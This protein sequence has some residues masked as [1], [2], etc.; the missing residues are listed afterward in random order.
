MSRHYYILAALLLLIFACSKDK[1]Y[2]AS[3]LDNELENVIN[4]Y[5]GTDEFILPESDDYQ[6]IPQDP[7]NP[8]SQGKIELGKM[9]FYETGLALAPIHDVAEGTYS[10]ATCHIPSAGFRPG[11]P[12]GIADG[13]A[14]FGDNGEGRFMGGLYDETELDVQGAR[15]LSVLNVAFVENTSWNG[16]FGGGGVNVG[17]EA[18]WSQDTTTEINHLGYA[19]LESQNIEGLKIHRMVVNKEIAD[20][21]GYTSYFDACFPEYPEEERY[22]L[23]TASFAISAYLRSLLTTE[24]PFQL[25]LKGD[26]T[27]LTDSEKRGGILFFD[28]ANCASCHREANLGSNTFYALGVN[29]LFQNAASFNTDENDPRNFGR[30]GFTGEAEDM[31]KFKVPQLYNMA[32]APFYFHGASKESLREVVEYFNLAIPENDRVPANLIAPNFDPLEL[33]DQEITDLEAFLANALRDPNLE[34]YVPEEV[35]SGNCFPNNDAFSQVD[36]GCN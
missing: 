3:A 7:F 21:Y 19:G 9:L 16:Q 4:R 35:L 25:W 12:Q 24:A 29:D 1:I 5:G 10:C 11:R 31:F 36:L 6:N 20:T 17:T 23:E 18:L 32:D 22:T 26:H 2:V 14:G 27:A 13:G 28:K 34:R 8:L 15:P 33:S 30:G